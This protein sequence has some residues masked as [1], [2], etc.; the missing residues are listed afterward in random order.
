MPRAARQHAACSRSSAYRPTLPPDT[1][2]SSTYPA[3]ALI[4]PP[5]AHAD[6]ST[7]R[8]YSMAREKA[9]DSAFHCAAPA[10]PRASTPRAPA[11][12]PA[13]PLQM[14]DT[15]DLLAYYVPNLLDYVESCDTEQVW[16][17]YK[18]YVKDVELVFDH[19][20]AKAGIDVT[21]E[22][23][24]WIAQFGVRHAEDGETHKRLL[25]A[26]EHH[27]KCKKQDE[28]REERKRKRA[29]LDEE[30]EERKRKSAADSGDELCMLCVGAFQK[31]TT[32]DCKDDHAFCKTCIDQWV[33]KAGKVIG[34]PTCFTPSASPA[35][36][37]AR[38]STGRPRLTRMR[39]R[40]KS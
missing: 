7:H 26:A 9:F 34:C 30:R 39:R 16:A 37:M 14:F 28:E 4:N 23:L 10:M 3:G 27:A 19:E 2:T 31:R 12:L 18:A 35:V 11:D 22:E 8:S 40:D 21:E 38:S 17:D 1:G 29:K 5:S 6:V 15:D 32:V 24:L 20:L 36:K 33:Q 13:R 25:D